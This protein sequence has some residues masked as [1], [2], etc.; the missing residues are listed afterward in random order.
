V[1]VETAAIATTIAIVVAV[2]LR[3]Q[4]P[5]DEVSRLEQQGKRVYASTYRGI[6]ATGQYETADE[7]RTRA[8]G[9]RR[10]DVRVEPHGNT[11]IVTGVE[12]AGRSPPRRRRGLAVEPTF[13]IRQGRCHPRR[14]RRSSRQAPPKWRSGSRRRR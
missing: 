7:A 6:T 14:P 5:A 12:T 11:A 9:S 13:P 3:A 10:Q 4:S 1:K 8:D 2:T